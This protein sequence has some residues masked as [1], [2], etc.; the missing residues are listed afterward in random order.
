MRALVDV[1]REAGVKLNPE[2]QRAVDARGLVFVSAGAGTGKTKVLVERFARAVC[3]EGV[4]VESILVITYTEKAAG[5][6]RSRIRAGLVERGRPDL[7]RE[8]DG[9]WIS[10]IH[11]FCHRL[12]RSHPFAAGVDPRFR[13]LDDSQGRVLRSEAF[14]EALTAFCAADDPA[15]LRLL[16]V[17]GTD[18]LRRMLTGVY[19]TLRSAGRELVLELGERPSLSGRVDEFREAARCLADDEGSSDAQRETARQAVAYLDADARADRIFDLGDLRLRGER[20]ASYE[21]ARKL[22]EQAALDELAAAD[23][24]L[25]QELLNGFAAAYQEGKD[26]E[27]ALDFEDLQLRARDLLRDDQAI[28]EREQLRFRSIMVDEF[29]DTNRLQCELIDLLSSGPAG[30]ELFFVGDEFQSI[31]GFR[32]ADVQVFRERRVQAGEGVLPLT[33]NYRSRPEVLAVVNHLF[34]ADFGDE[35]QPLAASGDFPDP[36]FGAPVELLVTD[37]STYSGTD[38]HWRRGEARAIA[39]RI[40]ELIDAG[41]AVAGEIVLLFA[42]GTDAEWYEEELRALDVPTYRGTG[43]G[44]FGQQQVVDL[45]AYL[46]LLRN[47]YDDEALVSVLASPL[48]GVSNDA[49]ALLRRAATKRPLFVAR[50]RELP[51]T[52]AHRDVQLLRA[53]RQRYDRLTAALARLSLERL[54]ERVVAEH[55]YDL[56]VLARWDGRRRYANLRKLARLARS[57][58][59]LRGPDVEGFVRFVRDQESVGARELEAVAEEEGADAVRL[60]TIHAAK[61]LEFKVVVV[62]DAGR[63]KAP[64][65]SHEILALSDGRFGFRVA[66]PITSKPRGAYAYDAVQEARKEE[67]R[68]ERL[69]LYYVAMTRAIDRLIVSGSIDPTRTSDETTPIGWV[70]G[71]LDAKGEIEG[72][73]REP[74]ELERE[75]ARVIL[76]VDRHVEEA[77][78][79]IV[80]L[81]AEVGQLALF[82]DGGAGGTLPVLVPALPPLAEVPAPPLHRVRRLSF[83]ALAL[84]DRCSYRYYAE[85][86]VGMRPTDERLAPGGTTGLAATEIGDAVHRLLELVNLQEPIPPED[87]AGLVRGWYPKVS[88]EELERIAGFVQSYCESELARRVA[89]LPSARPERPFAFEHDGVLLRGRLDMLQLD[90]EQAIVIDYKTNSL[91]EGAPEEIVEHDYHLQRLVYA[92]ACFR[93]GAREV[94]VVYHFLE[95]SDAVV[96]TV[97]RIEQIAE[98]EAEL[99]DAIAK[100]NAGEF[101]PTPSEYICAGCPALDVVC[102]GPGLRGPSYAEHALAT[103]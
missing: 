97:F 21:E 59:E 14:A 43:R 40:R 76:R 15:R 94:E 89:T 10:T 12:L 36:V 57:Y 47:R 37:K 29:Q 35:F 41:D 103:V 28:R 100:I 64:P 93:A 95:R 91:A 49:L 38:L 3:D 58:E 23:R 32:H 79:P 20:A 72:A 2:Q 5:E 22:V 27:S 19:E 90:G 13:V 11:G 17:Y 81:P 69:R 25:L 65:S 52:L 51:E 45:L 50:E 83:S 4:D 53:F 85:R 7:A 74:V 46:R 84:F 99:S 16:A 92:L 75:G 78:P 68:A 9:A 42:A 73:G 33:M 24:D 1:P 30:H 70:L 77:A 6:L 87:L 26:R 55:D 61:G 96:S 44:Y 67:E 102:A 101:R 82:E 8:L 54:C 62:A 66:D 98:L 88:D 80:E 60:L 63:D 31:Y 56:A 48:V 39:R 34:G 71:R 86:V 18:G